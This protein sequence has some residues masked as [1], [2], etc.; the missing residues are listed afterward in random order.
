MNR[1][2]AMQVFT[3]IVD[4]NSFSAAAHSLHITRSSVTTIMQALEA[5]LKVRLLNRTTRRISLTPDGA[6]YYERCARI[7]ADIEE[8]ERV[9]ARH[10]P[11]RGK[12]KVDMPGSIGKHVIVP[13]LGDFQSRYPD[14]ELMLGVGDTA[15]DLVQDS[16]DCAIRMGQ[17]QD[18]TLV[19]RCL[20]TADVVTVASRAY[21][22]RAGVPE[23]L[24]DLA[25]HTAVNYFPGKTGRIVQMDFIVDGQ[26]TAPRL[27]SRLAANDAD[28]YLQCGLNGLGLIQL[29]RF[30]AIP[31]L[32]AGELVEVLGRWRP[33]PLPISAVY[34]R[35]RYLSPLVRAFVDWAVERFAQCNLL[36]AVDLRTSA[37]LEEAAT[38]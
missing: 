19:A 23:T 2:Q 34:P 21:L 26:A 30:L 7:L 5:H 20:G 1:L 18:S 10:V 27:H 12:L 9:I 31:H 16:T 17:L 33:A 25:Q 3:R 36:R 38:V 22:A 13:A 35:D 24:A 15:V 37:L 29:P 14:I 4:G 6:A 28:A 11:P 8:S 32:E